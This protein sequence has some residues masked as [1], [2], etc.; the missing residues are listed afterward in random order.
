LSGIKRFGRASLVATLAV[1]L[2][3]SFVGLSGRPAAASAAD[4]QTS[5]LVFTDPNN[6]G[7]ISTHG[8]IVRI[9]KSGIIGQYTSGRFEDFAISGLQEITLNQATGKATIVGSFVA[10]SPDQ[11]SSF[12]L[13]YTGRADLV[14]NTASGRFHALNGT[15]DLKGLR[16]A[17]TIAADYLGNFTFSGADIGLC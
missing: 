5:F 2:M 1:V 17:G 7:T 3:A 10:T 9:R 6:V 14:A 16:A 4:C 11:Q 8:D 12:T 13:R 15:G